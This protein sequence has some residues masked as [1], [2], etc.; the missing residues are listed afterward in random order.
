MTVVGESL[1]AGRREEAVYY[2]KKLCIISEIIVAASCLVMY[3]LVRPITHFGGMEPASAKNVHLHGNLDH[4]CQTCCIGI[5]LS[6]RHM[7]SV[8]LEM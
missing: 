1:G 8:R 4:D 5:F 3:A 6:F 2:I 7:D